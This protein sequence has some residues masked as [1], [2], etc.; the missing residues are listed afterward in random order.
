ME[1]IDQANN[2]NRESIEVVVSPVHSLSFVEKMK[3]V[4]IGV[5][6]TADVVA[7]GLVGDSAMRFTN[8]TGLTFSPVNPSPENLL[9]THLNTGYPEHIATLAEMLRTE[10]LFKKILRQGL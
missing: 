1:V 7:Y 9:A 10:S 4:L 5:E 3:E 8:C 2:R 6:D